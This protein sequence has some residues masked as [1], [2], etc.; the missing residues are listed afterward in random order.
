MNVRKK[1]HNYELEIVKLFK[2]LGFDKAC[3]TRASSRMLDDC[4]VDLNFIP[5]LVQ[6]KAGYE[7]ARPKFEVLKEECLELINKK[8]PKEEA[9]LL[10]KKPYILFHKTKGNK[11][12]V[13]VDVDFFKDLLQNKIYM[14]DLILK[15]L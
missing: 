5:Y 10:T 11:Q 1:G 6:C 8:Y 15:R 12:S 7:K 14:S 4:K 2:E 13:T 9:D 3:S